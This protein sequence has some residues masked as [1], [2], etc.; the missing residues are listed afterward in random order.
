MDIIKKS[1]SRVHVLYIHQQ[2]VIINI[3]L[4][5]MLRTTIPLHTITNKLGGPYNK[6]K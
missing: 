6:I 3:F 4:L 2:V 1:F 5:R